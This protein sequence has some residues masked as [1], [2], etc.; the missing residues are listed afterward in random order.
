MCCIL[1]WL[2]NVVTIICGYCGRAFPD[3]IDESNC[4]SL[5]KQRDVSVWQGK[6]LEET[7][8]L[9]L[10]FCNKVCHVSWKKAPIGEAKPIFS[11]SSV[12]WR[13]SDYY[14]NRIK[15]VRSALTL[16]NTIKVS[17][18]QRIYLQGLSKTLLK[19]SSYSMGPETINENVRDNAVMNVLNLYLEAV[20]K[21]LNDQ[22]FAS[23]T[24]ESVNNAT[25]DHCSQ[26]F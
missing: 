18:L 26:F 5:I 2:I 16:I 14:S 22:E 20:R 7:Y 13:L 10:Y 17:N 9:T 15:I 21:E 3:F 19:A 4:N 1:S 12:E 24:P 8:T 23:E 11:P 6:R 25:C